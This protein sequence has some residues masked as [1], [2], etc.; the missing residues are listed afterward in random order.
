[1][2][3]P[4]WLL[5]YMVQRPTLIAS[6]CWGQVQ[7]NSTTPSAC[8][9]AI[10][11]GRKTKHGKNIVLLR[12]VL[13]SPT[14]RLHPIPRLFAHRDMWI[15]ALGRLGSV[16]PTTGGSLI[17]LLSDLFGKASLLRFMN[18]CWLCRPT[19]Q[20]SNVESKECLAFFRMLVF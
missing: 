1:M 20:D 15:G 4:V 10:E 16:L 18:T 11:A 8:F 2:P 17:A 14:T 9:E 12:T 7:V 5:L 3:A 6:L 13:G 19:D